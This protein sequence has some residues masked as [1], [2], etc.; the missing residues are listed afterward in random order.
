MQKNFVIVNEVL[1][2]Y[3]GSENNVIIPTGVT[4]IGGNAF[5]NS[6]TLTSVTIPDGV[7]EIGWK[8]FENCARLTSIN[9]PDSVTH[10]RQAAFYGTAYYN[11]DANW[12]DGMLYVGHH[13]IGVKKSISGAHTI[14]SGTRTIEEHAFAGCTGLSSIGIP[15]SV[16]EIGF[17]VFEGCTSLSSITIPDS[18]M[19]IEN[20]AFADCTSLTSIALPNRLTRIGNDA[21]LNTA[22]YNNSANWEEGAIYIGHYLIK[23]KNSVMGAY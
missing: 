14:K 5:S 18:V 3:N 17:C 1:V 15:D 13:L 20:L 23:V 19:I 12:E 22:Y 8:A 21:F 16:T 10:I 2:K 6:M 9:M 7:T 4:Q 11:D